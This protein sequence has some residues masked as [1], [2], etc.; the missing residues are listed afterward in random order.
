MTSE[1]PIAADLGP[2]RIIV[3]DENPADAAVTYNADEATKRWGNSRN[4]RSRGKNDGQNVLYADGHVEWQS[5]PF[6]GMCR[7][8]LPNAAA[9]QRDHIYRTEAPNAPLTDNTGYAGGQSAILRPA[10]EKDAILVPHRV[11]NP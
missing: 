5:S 3:D 8:D 2:G 9:K 7:T 11:A 10:T 4:H 1:M 6:C